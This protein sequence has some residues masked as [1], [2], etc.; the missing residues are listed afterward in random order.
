MCKEYF[1]SQGYCLLVVGDAPLEML[2]QY[3]ETQ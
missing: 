1:W 2:K 3:I